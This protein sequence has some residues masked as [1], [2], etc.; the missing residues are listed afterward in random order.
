MDKT[1]R[2]SFSPTEQKNLIEEKGDARNKDKLRLD[3]SHYT[4]S[5]VEDDID[6]LF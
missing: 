3:D 6:F 2:R 5:H 1:A 4:E